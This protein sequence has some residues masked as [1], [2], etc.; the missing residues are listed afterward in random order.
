MIV[1]G[2]FPHQTRSSTHRVD[3]QS[4]KVTDRVELSLRPDVL[5]SSALTGRMDGRQKEWYWC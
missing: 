2:G 5:M 3:M 4:A 1:S